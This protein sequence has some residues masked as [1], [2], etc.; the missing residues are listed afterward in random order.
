[1]IVGWLPF[2][3]LSSDLWYKQK[4]LRPLLPKAMSKKDEDKEAPPLKRLAAV[5]YY[6][7]SSL[8]VQFSTK[9]RLLFSSILSQ[10]KRTSPAINTC[11]L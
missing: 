8:A 11:P 5:C 7:G 4:Q 9:A 3:H 6:M 10:L 1:M 2:D